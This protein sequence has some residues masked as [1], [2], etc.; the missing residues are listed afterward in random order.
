MH[1]TPRPNDPPLT[2]VVELQHQ[3][4]DKAL[5]EHSSN[6]DL[7]RYSL[8]LGG[9]YC[10]WSDR[11]WALEVLSE[12]VAILG[13]LGI[14]TTLHYYEGRPQAA[15][16]MS[17][18]TL[19]GVVALLATVT[20]AALMI[21]IATGISNRKWLLFAQRPSS[22]RTHRLED[23]QTFDAA[24]RGAWGSIKLLWRAK[25]R[26]V[27][28][29][30][31]GVTL[32]SLA[33]STLTQNALSTA[34]RTVQHSER[35]SLAGDVQRSERYEVKTGGGNAYLL[36][37][38]KVAD[39]TALAAVY[40][41]L[42]NKD[43]AVLQTTCPTGNCSWPTVPSIGVCQSCFD[44]TTS[45]IQSC[46]ATW[47]DYRLLDSEI[48]LL[49]WNDGNRG[50]SLDAGS[51]AWAGYRYPLF[52]GGVATAQY[53]YSRPNLTFATFDFVGVSGLQYAGSVDGDG[54]F[55][56]PKKNDITATRCQ[57]WACIQAHDVHFSDGQQI[58]A[59]MRSWAEGQ[60]GDYKEMDHTFNFTNIPAAFNADS[61]TVYGFD[62]IALGG[63]IG[64]V[65]SLL[66]GVVTDD[67]HGDLQFDT[68]S[69]F[70][71]T[72]TDGIGAVWAAADRLD[73]FF[74]SLALS[75]SNWMRLT[76]V[77]S[78]KNQY[79][80]T[81]MSE[82]VYFMVRWIWLTFPAG[83][84]ALS[85]IFLG[86]SIVQACRSNVPAWKDSALAVLYANVDPGLQPL[87]S[88]QPREAAKVLRRRKV[89]LVGNERWW[90]LEQAV[91]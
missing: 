15:W 81:V 79:A 5:S 39:V 43:V 34:I 12:L 11:L 46:N 2:A 75:L 23:F 41:G 30:G 88:M 13:M 54:L 9:D 16:R 55:T 73:T 17:H 59:P 8:R 87:A 14:Y 32:L 35:G 27:A 19:N 78:P 7:A 82:E 60:W 53:D 86:L 1:A 26:H 33:F 85:S 67:R 51:A 45:L 74:E 62:T 4:Q 64:S 91:D 80:G 56:Y 38:T 61:D 31:A 57:L 6:P 40:N 90:T 44:M 28:S 52:V 70:V 69:S 83:L 63:I 29:L 21:P 89:Q 84:V 66:D 47:C 37:N 22:N 50:I 48:G 3:I 42:F 65:T 77:S 71:T 18:L 68:Y 76:G 20:K 58:L 25:F 10:S 36:N 49:T 24:S 72:S